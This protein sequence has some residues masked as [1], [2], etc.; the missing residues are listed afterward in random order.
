[1]KELQETDLKDVFVLNILFKSIAWQNQKDVY[2]IL[3][4]LYQLI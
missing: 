1:M 2:G 4:N 3:L